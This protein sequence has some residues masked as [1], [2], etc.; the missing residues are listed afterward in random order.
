MLKASL[1]GMDCCAALGAFGNFVA[2]DLRRSYGSMSIHGW[3]ALTC[4]ALKAVTSIRV[5]C[6]RGESRAD[7]S[8]K[9]ASQTLDD[10]GIVTQCALGRRVDAGRARHAKIGALVK[11]RQTNQL[12]DEGDRLVVA[13]GYAGKCVAIVFVHS[14]G[15][16]VNLGDRECRKKFE[17][18]C[19]TISKDCHVWV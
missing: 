11:S 18:F 2:M 15:F 10:G 17:L 3:I 19:L 4:T 1:L 13:K 14:S 8:I 5:S 7:R 12:M 6:A 9:G 16:T